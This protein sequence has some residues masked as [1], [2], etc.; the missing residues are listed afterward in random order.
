MLPSGAGLVYCEEMVAVWRQ[1]E[2]VIGLG[3]GGGYLTPASLIEPHPPCTYYLRTWT[4]VIP[5]TD[6][7]KLGLSAGLGSWYEWGLWSVR[8]S[9]DVGCPEGKTTTKWHTVVRRGRR[10]TTGRTAMISRVGRLD[11]E[12]SDGS[13]AREQIVCQLIHKADYL[14]YIPTSGSK[15]VSK[16]AWQ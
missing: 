16:S 3:R 9:G 15:A 5:E 12:S 13:L 4:Q 11:S 8:K 6:G 7:R 2:V 14:R 10:E 1:R